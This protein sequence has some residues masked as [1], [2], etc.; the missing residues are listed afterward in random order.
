MS[1]IKAFGSGMITYQGGKHKIELYY[2]YED[3]FICAQACDDLSTPDVVIDRLKRCFGET[4]GELVADL[5]HQFEEYEVQWNTTPVPYCECGYQ[6]TKQYKS[7]QTMEDNGWACTSG[8]G[9]HGIRVDGT[10]RY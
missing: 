2:D 6:M 8:C 3:G 1:E 10:G 9:K 7:L 5:N 4:P